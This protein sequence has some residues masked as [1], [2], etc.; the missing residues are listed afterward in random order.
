MGMMHKLRIIVMLLAFAFVALFF[1]SDYLPSN[2]YMER[3][4]AGIHAGGFK[5]ENVL[6]VPPAHESVEQMD[7]DIGEVHVQVCRY[8]EMRLLRKNV[9][10]QTPDV[11]ESLVASMTSSDTSGTGAYRNSVGKNGY[12]MIVVSG[13][14]AA[15]RDRI[16][17]IFESL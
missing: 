10:Y 13:P 16:V 11:G 3:I 7:L 14:D 17:S 5:I 9:V 1:L 15:L 6:R 8:D 2:L 12:F 4:A